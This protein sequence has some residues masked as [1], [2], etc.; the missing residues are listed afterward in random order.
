MFELY[1][2]FNNMSNFFAES[3][4]NFQIIKDHFLNFMLFMM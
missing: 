1:T 3:N 4:N 2:F